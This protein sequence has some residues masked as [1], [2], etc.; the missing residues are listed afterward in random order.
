MEDSRADKKANSDTKVT[1]TGY[2]VGVQHGF[3]E[4]GRIHGRVN[5][6]LDALIEDRELAAAMLLSEQS[7]KEFLLDEPD[8]YTVRDLK[9]G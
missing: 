8:L 4:I 7:L 2:C 6:K 5:K 9:V 1:D 3:R